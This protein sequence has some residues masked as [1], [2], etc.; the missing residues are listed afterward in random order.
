MGMFL[1]HKILENDQILITDKNEVIT[2]EKN[3]QLTRDREEIYVFYKKFGDKMIKILLENKEVDNVK[4]KSVSIIESEKKTFKIE[5]NTKGLVLDCIKHKNSYVFLLKNGKKYQIFNKKAE[6]EVDDIEMVN[7][8][9]N[10]IV[11]YKNGKIY[12]Y[13]Q[14]KSVCEVEKGDDHLLLLTTHFLRNNKLY[15]FEGKCVRKLNFNTPV[16]V[17]EECENGFYFATECKIYFMSKLY[18]DKLSLFEYIGNILYISVEEQKVIVKTSM[19]LYVFDLSLNLLAREIYYLDDMYEIEK[20]EFKKEEEV[21]DKL[22]AKAATVEKLKPFFINEEYLSSDAFAIAN[23]VVY[24]YKEC[25]IT[26]KF[27]LPRYKDVFVDNNF[28]ICITH[29]KVIVFSLTNKGCFLFAKIKTNEDK[30]IN[31]FVEK[32]TLHLESPKS[33]NIS[34]YKIVTN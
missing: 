32:S 34:T 11:F 5:F 9:N 1:Q 14:K 12:T 26:A 29:K 4:V 17:A 19:M 24:V 27:M 33:K 7:V 31:A 15:T 18:N 8:A 30:V 10:K 6:C 21:K 20:D 23:R 3:N 22:L 16:K 13:G 2:A 25:A 28:I